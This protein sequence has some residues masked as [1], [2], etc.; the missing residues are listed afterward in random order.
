MN[1]AD[2]RVHAEQEA[3]ELGPEPNDPK[4]RALWLEEKR[5]AVELLAG[6]EDWNAPLLRRAALRVASEW[7]NTSATELLLDAARVA[8]QLASTN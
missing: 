8:D 7:S 5:G 1:A 6:L 4:D 2:L 3:E